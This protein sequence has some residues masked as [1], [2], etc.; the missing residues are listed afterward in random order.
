MKTLTYFRY[1]QNVEIVRILI[2]N[3]NCYVNNKEY[4]VNF[5]KCPV[6]RSRDLSCREQGGLDCARPDK[7]IKNS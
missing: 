2:L 5:S 6:E 7:S 4:F 1:W 3:L